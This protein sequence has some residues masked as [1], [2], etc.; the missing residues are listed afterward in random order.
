MFLFYPIFILLLGFIF[1]IDRIDATPREY[2]FSLALYNEM[3]RQFNQTRQPA[4]PE[5]YF[6]RPQPEEAKKN[7]KRAGKHLEKRRPEKRN[8]RKMQN[9]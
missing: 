6:S 1:H 9:C 8:Q 5:K 3:P 4:T 2:Q 7:G